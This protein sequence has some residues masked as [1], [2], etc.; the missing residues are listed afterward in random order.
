MSGSA[1]LLYGL[2]VLVFLIAIMASIALHELGHLH[3]AKKFGCRVSEYMVGFGPTLWSRRR[4]EC[5]YGL[6]LIPLGGYV[7]IIGMFPP[8]TKEQAGIAAGHVASRAAG[9]APDRE[10]QRALGDG[11]ASTAEQSTLRLRRSNT[12]LFALMVSQTRAA[13]F[14]LIEPGDRDRL[15]FKLPTTK[16]ILVM[17][18]GPGVNIALAFLCFLVVF[19]VYGT[20][21]LVPTGQP[22]IAAVSDCVIPETENRV[23]CRPGDPVGPGRA[24]GLESGDRIVAF[25]GVQVT[26][27][28]HL[29]ALIQ[30][31][32]AGPMDLVVARGGEELVL[33]RT[34]SVAILR[35]LDGPG[36]GQPAVVGF[37]GIN[38]ESRTLVTRHGPLYVM[39]RMGEMTAHAVVSVVGLP[40][41]VANVAQAILGVEQRAPDGPMSVIG[42]FRIAG[43]V[44]SSQAQGLDVAG[45]AAMLGMIVGSFNLFIGVFNLIPLLPLDGGHIIGAAWEGTRRRLARLFK[46]P[47]PGFVNVAAQLPLAYCL[48][49]ALLA[50]SLV[51]MIGDVLVPLR[52]GL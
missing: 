12:G 44:A 19:G 11:T 20:R 10:Q 13:E 39:A 6:K 51:L 52:S 4:G 7:K 38:P 40:G 33:P 17:L 34:H 41:R 46:R 8:A 28:D 50:M 5:E 24:A 45:K 49:L 29:S 22:V 48:G 36:P 14:E 16:K 1:I 31:N 30:A 25:N 47:D 15:F 32:G 26:S 23:A 2:G 42:G 37:V 18:A 27:W 3:Y 21:E 43:E 9:S 35:D